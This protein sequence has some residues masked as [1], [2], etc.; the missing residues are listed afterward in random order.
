[1]AVHYCKTCREPAGKLSA[2]GDQVR[3]ES[4]TGTLTQALT[5]AVRD[6]LGDAAGLYALDPE[7]TPFYCP[8]CD[9]SYCG[10]HWVRWD[11]FDDDE[12]T[13]RDSIRGTCPQGHERMLED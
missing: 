6:A 11:V 10:E 1:V 9:A 12:P 8:R 2:D 7:L 5:P 4:F 3:R 13:W